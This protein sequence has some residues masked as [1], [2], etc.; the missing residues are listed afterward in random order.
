MQLGLFA[1]EPPRVSLIR[2]ATGEIEYQAGVF[3]DATSTRLFVRLRG[4]VRWTA[5]RRPMYDRIVDVPRLT[6]QLDLDAV[7]RDPEL[8]AMRERVEAVTGVKYNSISLNLYRDE[9]DSVAWHNDHEDELIPNPVIALVSLGA[10]R[11]MRIRSKALPR[12]TFRL[13]LE[14]GSL[15]VMKG[16]TQRYWEHHIP[17]ERRPVGPRIS[18]AFRQRPEPGFVSGRD[19]SARGYEAARGPSGGSN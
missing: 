4:S 10:V 2:G 13:D 7:A 5:E 3:D 16:A 11:E 18:V 17:K 14:A 19:G 9:H 6:A 8:Q 1:S 12:K 15:L